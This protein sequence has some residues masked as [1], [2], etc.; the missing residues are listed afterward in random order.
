MLLDH[1]PGDGQAQPHS[2]AHFFGREEGCE[3]AGQHLSR[4]TRSVVDHL[5]SDA[6]G[7]GS[8][9][10]P[11]MPTLS[12]RIHRILCEVGNGLL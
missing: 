11:H 8:S 7:L 10:D 2:F 12:N 4:D 9:S 3:D 5:D 6:S 1:L